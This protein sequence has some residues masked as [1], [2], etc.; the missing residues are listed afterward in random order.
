MSVLRPDTPY[1]ASISG[2]DTPPKVPDVEMDILS[3][4]LLT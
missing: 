1:N 2:V 3:G 4:S